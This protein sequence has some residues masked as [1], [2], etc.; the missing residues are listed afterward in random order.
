M[1][2]N[3]RL[4]WVMT[5]PAEGRTCVLTWCLGDCDTEVP[6]ITGYA[7]LFCLEKGGH[8]LSR[9]LKLEC[10]CQP[11]I[12]QGR[13]CR[14][15]LAWRLEGAGQCCNK[16][17]DCIGCDQP[18]CQEGLRNEGS[19]FNKAACFI[20]GS[21][22]LMS[23]MDPYALVWSRQT[24][25]QHS[26]RLSVPAKLRDVLLAWAHSI[27]CQ[28]STCRAASPFSGAAGAGA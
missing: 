2:Q 22:T 6:P 23:D 24:E 14:R 18:I 17:R 20:P 4:Q 11:R 26:G 15:L 19:P 21:H 9:S 16:A 12:C 10:S 25:R 13:W 3:R 27:G 7:V 8:L 1:E 5:I 28:W